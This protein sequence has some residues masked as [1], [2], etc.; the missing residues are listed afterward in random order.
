MQGQGEQTW[1]DLRGEYI[2]IFSYYFK[3]IALVICAYDANLYLVILIREIKGNE[4]EGDVFLRACACFEL[5]TN[6]WSS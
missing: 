5:N 4:R 2:Y 6:V 3:Y 1:I